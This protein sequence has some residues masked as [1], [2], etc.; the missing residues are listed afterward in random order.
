MTDC[1]NGA[2]RDALPDYLNDRLDAARRREVESHLAACDA[3]REELS[4][5]RAL[6][7]TMRR[8]P[9]VDAESIAAVIPPYR[10]PARRGWATRWRVA[11]AVVAIAVGGTSIALLRERAPASQADVSPRVAVVPVSPVDP[12]SVVATPPASG[13][14]GR[15]QAAPARRPVTAVAARELAIA[16]GSIGDLSDGE[17]AAL[18]EGIESLDGL[19]STEVESAEPVS[20][21]AQEKL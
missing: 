4:L 18:V 5:L 19:P 12:T 13:A 16:G 10:A 17:L 8:A 9:V 15:E 1:P 2:V 14:G 7:V 21:P 3:C 20:V 11:A 6:R